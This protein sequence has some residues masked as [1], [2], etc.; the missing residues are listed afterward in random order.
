MKLSEL[1]SQLQKIEK[2]HGS[3]SPVLLEEWNEDE[4]HLSS[5]DITEV[6]FIHDEEGDYVGISNFPNP[7]DKIS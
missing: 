7:Y 5:F 3:N 4:F 1:I 2:E 6:C